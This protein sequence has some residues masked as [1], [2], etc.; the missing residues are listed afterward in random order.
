MEKE[1][2]LPS[3][4]VQKRL[5]SKPL[6]EE[7]LLKRTDQAK[8]GHLPRGLA[9]AELQGDMTG[10]AE[11]LGD[12][13]PRVLIAANPNNPAS[14]LPEQ[15]A[16]AGGWCA[17]R[18][19]DVANLSQRGVIMNPE[20]GS[21]AQVQSVQ[22]VASW[23]EQSVAFD[24][25]VESVGPAKG[26][27]YAVISERQL[28]TNRVNS[29][30][31]Q[32]FGRQLTDAEQSKIER[33]LEKAEQMRAVMTKRYLEIATNNPN[34]VFQRV[35]DADIWNDIRKAQREMFLRAGLSLDGL[36]RRF[37]KDAATI[38]SS[39]IVWAMYSEPYFD[40]LRTKGLIT[41][42]TVFIV[43]PSLHTYADTQAGND[44]VQRIY[45]DKGI[46]FD[47]KGMNKNTG[48]IAFIECVTANGANVR[49]NLGVGEVPN[50]SNWDRM[51]RDELH[52]EAN[53]IINPKDNSLFLWGLNL[54]PFGNTRQALLQ[55]VALQ[56][57][58]QKEK[59]KVGAQF[60]TGAGKNDPAV[61][62]SIQRRVEEL[63]GAF[64]KQ[65]IE[66]N[67]I[68]ASNL[69]QLFENLTEGIEDL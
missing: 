37:P 68:I 38:K 48:F 43:E 35:V 41:S 18:T 10:F 12:F 67:G 58:F 46:Y 15:I 25:I 64:A 60:G 54:L 32:I 34:I 9:L 19:N 42:P 49:K 13:A 61:R 23:I 28:W 14:L 26:S 55:L 44:V 16:I 52:P 36:Q 66:Q 40:M 29:K 47:P 63:K 59:A 57:E 31:G 4:E 22:Q 53:A 56:D 5:W 24:Q 21:L 39:A 1:Q 17:L 65:V 69:R 2:I 33:S 3:T 50:V 6:G 45:Q 62:T 7:G 30:L 20:S 27:E 11:V 8:R 51:F